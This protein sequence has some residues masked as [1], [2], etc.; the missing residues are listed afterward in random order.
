M[1]ENILKT[2]RKEC[3]K[4][5]N[6]GKDGNLQSIFSSL[7]I[8]W[9]LYDQILKPE[10]SF[11]LSKGQSNLGLMVVLAHKNIISFDE[12]ET[13]C[14]FDSRISMQVD[15][16]KFNGEIK[17]SSGSLGHGLPIATGIALAK[18]IKNESGKVYCLCGDGE[19]NEGTMWESVIFAS[20]KKL[21]NLCVI[22]DNNKSL[23][24][25]INIGN[26]EDKISV[27]GF[28]KASYD[29]NNL[30]TL[31]HDLKAKSTR[32]ILININTIR[33]YGCKTFVE[34][35]SWFHRHPNE[36]EVERLIDEVEEF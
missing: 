2:L 12:L 6:I 13:F 32:P 34:D 28:N 4:I 20:S 23:N 33:G 7:P 5:S 19:F 35:N 9:I 8:L 21:N 1:P 26:L 18:K 24:K 36:N 17:V 10:D 16:T 11:V 31:P 27:F 15:R 14:Q 3:I 29:Y 25:M 30:H 22:I